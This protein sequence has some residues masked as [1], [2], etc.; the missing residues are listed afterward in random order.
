MDLTVAEVGGAASSVNPGQASALTVFTVTND[1]NT[2]QD[3]ALLVANLTS[4]DPAVHTN[5][6]TDADVN[7]LRAYADANGNGTYEPGTDTQTFIGSLAADATVTVF[8]V[9]DTPIG[10]IDGDVANVRLTAVTADAGTGGA[11][12]TVETAGAN[13]AGVDV[14]FA[15]AGNDG[16]ESADDGYIF[17]SADLTISK[18]NVII[19]DPFN[20]S[21]DPKAIPGATV[22]YA[23]ELTNN[24]A[25]SADSV[26]VTNVVGSELTFLT[27]QY[28][29]GASDV[30]I[31][32]GAGAATVIFCTS[33]ALDG[34]GCAL[35]G[36]T[37][38]VSPPGLSVGTT[39][40]DNPVRVLFRATIN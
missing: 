25:V 21:T 35:T 27:G 3:Y 19:D 38:E 24:G 40:T 4:A 10:A 6:D 22:E 15:D 30:R 2:T 31:E 13:T 32:V 12:I 8:V 33:A 17:S 26:L 7:N 37:L 23:I 14:V 39:A 28:N 16:E 20:G 9:V 34:D 5:L 36:S 1:G 29:A 18:S 11:T